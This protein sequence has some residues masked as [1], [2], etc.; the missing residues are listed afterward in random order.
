METHFQDKDILTLLVGVC[1]VFGSIV[2]FL[3]EQIKF[4]ILF[5]ALGGFILRFFM[6]KLDPFIYTWDEQFHALVAKNMMT[7]PFKPMLYV[8]PVLPYDLNSWVSCKVWLHKGPVF[9]WLIVISF[10]I[11]G[12]NEIAL[13]LPSII[14]STLMI[15]MIFRMGKLCINEKVGFFA[16]F[17]FASANYQL[18]MCTGIMASDHNDVAFMFFVC[19][20]FWAWFE[21]QN[22]GNK[23]W[24]ILIG[25]FSGLA[26]DTK[27][28][29]GFL[30]FFCWLLTIILSKEKRNKIVAYKGL[31]IS[32]LI[33]LITCAS[34]Y[35]YALV[36]F[37][38]EM[39]G[40]L[41][42]YSEHFTSV[43]EDHSGGGYY[44]L[45]LLS[46]HYG[47]IIPFILLPSIYLFYKRLENK[48]DL[49]I[50]L[51]TWVLFVE[52][53]YAIARTKMALFTIIIAPAIYIAVGALL[54]QIMEYL[55][56][57]IRRYTMILT[58]LFV[59]FIGFSN[60]GINEIEG[61]HTD[62]GW[63]VSQR[64]NY[65][66]NSNI[67]KD[68]VKQLPQKDY[69][70]FNCK[71]CNAIQA[72]FYSGM[73]AYN[74]IPDNVTCDSLEKNGIKLAVFNDGKLPVY[75]LNDNK[76][77]K[78]NYDIWHDK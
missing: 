25:L 59:A 41:K 77:L 55:R 18:E 68:I 6:I 14:M 8:S 39:S 78:L 32:I 49:K 3:K 35:I 52:I 73:T 26:V 42:E 4:S 63:M 12:V 27:W 45:D 69:V 36:R 76:I 70:L 37:P 19:A 48:K 44:H 20:S 67:F 11:F 5:L 72:M 66:H 65:I 16:A 47:W 30:V 74:N 22:S 54:Y 9:L 38:I 31:I 29:M 10:K 53:F 7:N 13:R 33:A 56:L 28:V 62:T 71:D 24:I 2:L 50:I 1:L 75:I 43:I 58:F 61:H 17:L 15:P 46:Q 51:V 34:W 21:Y 23:I 57:R 60:I 40:T 64:A